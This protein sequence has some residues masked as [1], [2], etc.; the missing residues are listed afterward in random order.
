VARPAWRPR[1]AAPRC[2]HHAGHHQ[3][4]QHEGDGAAL[5]RIEDVHGLLAAVYTPGVKAELADGFFEDAALSRIVVDNQ[6]ELGHGRELDATGYGRSLREGAASR[7]S[8][9]DR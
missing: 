5:W 6:H 4:E 9:R 3:I 8:A 7:Q 2:R 1:A